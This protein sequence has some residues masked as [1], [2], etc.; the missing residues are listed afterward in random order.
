[1]GDWA[2]GC[3]PK[4]I[5]PLA[6]K[7]MQRLFYSYQHPTVFNGSGLVAV[8]S[9]LVGSKFQLKVNKTFLTQTKASSLPI[10]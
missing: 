10:N 9:N 1:M 6:G 4:L 8:C 7:L 3:F 2:L 5:E